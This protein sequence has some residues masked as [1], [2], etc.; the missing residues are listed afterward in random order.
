MSPAG[1]A[2]RTVALIAVLVAGLAVMGRLAWW[3]FQGSLPVASRVDPTVVRTPVALTE[4]VTFGRFVEPTRFGQVV[5]V[6]GRYVAAGQFI[7]PG[8][9]PGERWVVTP[10]R[11]PDGRNVAVVRGTAAGSNTGSGSQQRV[12]GGEV[13]IRGYLQPSQAPAPDAINTDV[14][15]RR[16]AA[17]MYDGYVVLAAQVPPSELQPVSP[18][19]LV[20]PSTGIRPRNLAYAVQW[21]V[22]AAFAVYLVTRVIAG[23]YRA[24]RTPG[25][26]GPHPTPHAP[27]RELAG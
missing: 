25:P 6:R 16:W 26:P 18:A 15:V 19:A 9:L 11:T 23:W 5:T 4:V 12:P 13:S 24:P 17:P 20:G 7:S 27:E 2:L 14:L 22:F 3:Q 10:L 1:R 21:V 8:A